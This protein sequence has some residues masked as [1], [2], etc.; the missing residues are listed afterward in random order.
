MVG[1]VY[2][3]NLSWWGEQKFRG[4]ETQQGKLWAINI[5]AQVNGIHD[6][7]GPTES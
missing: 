7:F 3:G 5:R 4:W 2:W 6:S 1:E